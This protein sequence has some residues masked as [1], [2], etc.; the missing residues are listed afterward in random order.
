MD[1]L[2]VRAAG[3]RRA[4]DRR[5]AVLVILDALDAFYLGAFLFGFVFT[6]L[7]HLLGAVHLLPHGCKGWHGSI[8]HGA[9]HGAGHH[10]AGHALGKVALGLLNPGAIVAF[11]TWFGG[12][13]YEARHALG[14]VPPVSLAL[15]VAGGLVGAAI[16]GLFLVKVLL[17]GDPT[18]DPDDYRLPGTLC[19]VSAT[20]RPDGTGE[21]VYEQ[22]GVRHVAPARARDGRTL[23]RGSATVIEAYERGV[24]WVAPQ[25]AGDGAE[26]AVEPV[27]LSGHP[28]AGG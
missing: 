1:A 27:P 19:R 18:M 16:V 8:A 9:H 12:V 13:G 24:A 4:V 10:P 3:E 21:V 2:A 22:M 5:P 14:L 7:S 6:A 26:P 15:G 25:V 28:G 17:A 20:I 23:A 11:V